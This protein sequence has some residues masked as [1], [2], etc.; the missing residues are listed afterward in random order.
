MT[1]TIAWVILRCT[2]R[3]LA[4]IGAAPVTKP[5]PVPDAEDWYANLLWH[6]R[7]KCLLLTHSSTLFSVFEADVRAVDLRDTSHFVMRLIGGEL[8]S[9]GLPPDLFTGLNEQVILAKTADRSVLGCMNDMSQL[10]GHAIAASGG[11]ARTNLSALN[12]SLRRN[13][14]SARGYQRPIDMA[15]ARTSAGL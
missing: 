15:S 8:A 1:H 6:D 5:A 2:A 13:I 10:C 11:L 7:R 3:L 9:E 4:V 14:N 12:R